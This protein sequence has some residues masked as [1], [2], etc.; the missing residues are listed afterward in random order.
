MSKEG[1]PVYDAH[2][3]ENFVVR[4][5]LCLGVFNFPMAAKF[6]NSV[7]APGTEH[8]NRCDIVHPKTKSERRDR[9]ISSTFSFDVKD[10]KYSRVLERTAAIMSSLKSSTQLSA[11]AIKDALLLNGVTDRS[12]GLTMRLTEARG[13]GTFDIREL[14]IV[15]PSH[16]L[17]YNIA[18]NLLMKA[19]EALSVGQRDKFVSEMRRSSKHVPTH[20]ILSSF[21]PEKMGGTTLSMSDYAVLLTVGPTVLE[22]SVHTQ[23]TSAH[24]VDTLTALKALRHFATALFYRPTLCSDGEQAMRERQTVVEVQR[25]GESLMIELRRLLPFIGMGERPAVQCLLE[26]LYRTLPLVQLGSS[27]CELIFENFHQMAKREIGRSNHRNPAEYSM[28]RWRDTEQY[29]RALSMPDEYGV[30]TSWLLG[31][32]GIPLKAV[33]FHRL[34]PQR[35]LASATGEKLCGREALSMVVSSTEDFWRDHTPNAPVKFWRKARHP[36]RSFFIREGSTV[37]V[38][39][40]EE[41]CDVLNDPSSTGGQRVQFLRMRAIGTIAKELYLEC[42]W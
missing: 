19:Y 12:G 28:Q 5:F 6:S 24:A 30:P 8:C 18:S 1:V 16:L 3:K 10:T 35:R 21:E 13:P 22:Y 39:Q 17:Y 31:L 7:G 9:A 27:I 32:G 40:E 38:L 20:T 4:V 36:Q 29:S 14:V 2:S 11:E 15:A 42:E 33:S 26:L 37:S 34:A 41:A 25:L 23:S